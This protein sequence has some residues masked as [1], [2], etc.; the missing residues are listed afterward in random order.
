MDAPAAVVCAAF[1]PEGEALVAGVQQRLRSYGV[2][3]PR[4]PA[5][6]PHI[7]LSAAL[8]DVGDVGAV[9]TEIAARHAPFALRLDL[10]GTFARGS[11]VWLGT[12]RAPALSALQHDVHGSLAERWAPAFGE[13]TDPTRWVPHCTLARRA[14]RGAADRLRAGHHPLDIRVA[15][16]ATIVVGERGDAGYVRLTG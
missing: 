7:T 10:I 15:A 1:D 14:G 11:T 6:R 3:L 4:D 12:S 5:H 9:T 2:R 16:L 8:A 13:Q